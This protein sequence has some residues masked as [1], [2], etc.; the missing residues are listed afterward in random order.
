MSRTINIPDVPSHHN[1]AHASYK[2]VAAASK[3]PISQTQK[4]PQP[5]NHRRSS[6]SGKF[7]ASKKVV[8]RPK[9]NI[10]N[11]SP[12]EFVTILVSSALSASPEKYVVHKA[13][14]CHH[15]PYFTAAFRGDF[16]EGQTQSMT[17][18][19]VD[20][21]I[22][23][24]L[25]HWLYTQSIED[26]VKA[27]FV[28]L[29]QLWFLAERRL[30]P[31]LQNEVMNSI[32]EEI[33]KNS[34]NLTQLQE[35]IKLAYG[36][37]SERHEAGDVHE[38]LRKIIVDR[39]AFLSGARMEQLLMAPNPPITFLVDVTRAL[40]KHFLKSP[41]RGAAGST[42]LKRREMYY[43]D[44]PGENRVNS[45]VGVNRRRESDRDS[46]ASAPESPVNRSRGT[47]IHV[48]SS[49]EI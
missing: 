24:Q 9:A 30:M 27:K 40:N 32:R 5:N 7:K 39:Y 23:G 42:K 6:H 34:K 2:G 28:T 31:T 43:V 33:A 47:S 8:P 15:S 13:L 1:S 25:T 26:S 49:D 16:L 44:I 20:P 12:P 11:S 35:F 29:G 17:L 37:G 46:T 10:I 4:W 48:G 38:M 45:S 41:R 36:A 22:F 21:A 19:D 18:S 3:C 14:I